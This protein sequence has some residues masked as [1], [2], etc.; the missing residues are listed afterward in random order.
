MVEATQLPSA[1]VLGKEVWDP[2]DPP[3][4]HANFK[5]LIRLGSGQN[6]DPSFEQMGIGKVESKNI[7]L[8]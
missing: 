6:T 5:A 1:R 2:R 4:N 7:V 8:N 3:H